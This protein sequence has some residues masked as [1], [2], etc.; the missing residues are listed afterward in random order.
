MAGSVALDCSTWLPQQPPSA[1]QR[2]RR[3]SRTPP[4]SPDQ[5]CVGARDWCAAEQSRRERGVGL[6]SCALRNLE[7][8]A[9][10]AA[11]TKTRSSGGRWRS[12]WAA[13]GRC[14]QW[15]MQETPSS[16]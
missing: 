3:N 14:L 10:V 11:A 1:P 2:Q 8:Q 4:D 12:Q 5:N 6:T 13:A 16:C 15:T 7:C 9:Q